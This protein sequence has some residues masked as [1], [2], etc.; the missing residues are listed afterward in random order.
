[1]CRV[2]LMMLLTV[3]SNSAVA[4]W[5]MVSEDANLTIYADP[6]IVREAD[7]RVK[8]WWV[9]DFKAAQT[10]GG[11]VYLSSRK[12]YEFDCKEEKYRPLS[13][14][15]HSEKMAKG[16]VVYSSAPSSKNMEWGGVPPNTNGKLL[17]KFACGET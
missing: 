7:N 6:E 4:A 17:L 11:E 3:A 1:M 12:Q 14:S 16:D 13:F 10:N 5:V 9:A 8:L 2:I 15:R